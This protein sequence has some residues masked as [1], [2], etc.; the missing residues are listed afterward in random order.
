MEQP[1][2]ETLH[3][4]G[5]REAAAPVFIQ[6]FETANLKALRALT[7]LRLIQLLNDTG[8]PYDLVLAGDVRTFRDLTTPAGLKAIAGYAAGIGPSK[9]LVLSSTPDASATS[10]VADAHAHGLLVHVWTFRAENEFLSPPHRGT[11]APDERG[12]MAAEVKRFLDLGV[13]GFFTDHPDLGVRV[14]NGFLHSQ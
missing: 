12:D 11:G 3:R 14:R 9:A 8:R 1:L 13:D 2:V 10:L 7:R 5:Y 6:S 4:W